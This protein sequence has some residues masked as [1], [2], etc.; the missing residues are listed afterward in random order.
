MHNRAET[1][2]C[3]SRRQPGESGFRD[4]RT[5]DSAVSEAFFQPRSFIPYTTVNIHVFSYDKDIFITFHF[6]MQGFVHCVNISQQLHFIT[7][8]ILSG[9]LPHRGKVRSW[10]VP[11]PFQ[12]FPAPS[13]HIAGD[14]LP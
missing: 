11:P 7:L 9:T 8:R 3:R 14:V 10:L 13:L 12:L 6:L 1:A 2:Q 5:Y 4:R